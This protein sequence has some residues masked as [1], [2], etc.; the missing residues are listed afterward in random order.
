MVVNSSLRTAQPSWTEEM[1]ES[2]YSLNVRVPY[3]LVAELDGE[4]RQK[5]QSS[6]YRRWSPITGF[7]A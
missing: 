2:V 6:T 7:P 1:F 4:T 3:F 5:G